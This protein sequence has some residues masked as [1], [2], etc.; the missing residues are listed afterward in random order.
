MA[1]DIV[2]VHSG[3][4]FPSYINDCISLLIMQNVNVH[5]ILETKLLDKVINNKIKI[6]SIND[7]SD[8][9][10]HNYD[11]QNYDSNFRDAFYRRTSSR[12]IL[13][14]NYARL[15]NLKNFFHIENDIALFSNLSHIKHHLNSSVYDTCLIIDNY[16][17]CVP[18]IIWYKNTDASNKLANF[19]YNNNDTDD[20][21]NLAKYFHQNR[22]HV[23][24][25]P[26]VPFDLLDNKYNINYGNMYKDLL[27]VFDGAAIGQYLY[28][29]DS[30]NTNKNNTCGF[31]NE[32]CA[33]DYSKFQ[34]QSKPK[35]MLI[36]NNKKVPIN[37]IHMHCKNMG[38]LL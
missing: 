19:I 21:Q 27:S 5:L 37:N 38:Q 13:I 8:R 17:R 30:N 14:D 29:I 15:N 26:I 7:I 31:I 23:T 32:S 6:I 33:V 10:Y 20:M 9:R 22:L 28:G 2:L 36:F 16:W 11:I 3:S 12:F 25:F 35:P 34:I 24:N 4:F 18:S 1:T